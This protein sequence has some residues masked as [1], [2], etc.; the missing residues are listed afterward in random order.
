MNSLSTLDTSSP[1]GAVTI[2]SSPSPFPVRCPSF[3]GSN[4]KDDEDNDKEE[5]DDAKGEGDGGNWSC[6]MSSSLSLS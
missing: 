4:G 2:S 6:W 1:A 5:K 3:D